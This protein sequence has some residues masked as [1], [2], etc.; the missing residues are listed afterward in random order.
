MRRWTGSKPGPTTKVTATP[1]VTGVACES[2]G[3]TESRNPMS[4]AER[5]SKNARREHAREVAKKRQ[6]EERKRRLRNRIFL[7]GG[8]GLGHR[9]DRRRDHPGDQSPNSGSTDA[10]LERRRPEEHGH[11]RHPV[12]GRRRQGRAG[13]DRRCR[14]RVPRPSPVATTNADGAAKVVTY[15]DWACPV[16]KQFEAS[17]SKDI[18][19]RVARGQGDPRDP[20]G[21]DPRPQLPE[22]PLRQPRR[23]R[24]R[25]RRELRPRQLPLRPDGVLRQPAGRG[26]ERPERHA[27]QEARDE[28]AV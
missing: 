3:H 12:P 22:Q 8:I 17:Y 4:N 13:R 18:L 27:D 21:V 1:P 6:E 26:V 10:R 28:T 23:E 9:G 24:R 11:R 19:S 5:P 7:Q 15:I 2:R 25:L 16:C 20:P 14:A